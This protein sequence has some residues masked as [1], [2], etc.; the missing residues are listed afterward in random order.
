LLLLLFV[1]NN[2]QCFIG[3]LSYNHMWYH[4]V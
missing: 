2:K 4:H 3:S 1:P